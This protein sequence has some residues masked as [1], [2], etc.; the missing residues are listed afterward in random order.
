M[1]DVNGNKTT[2]KKEMVGCPMTDH[3]LHPKNLIFVDKTGC[4]TNMKQDGLV[5]GELHILPTEINQNIEFG[6]CGAT[7]D[8]HFSVLCFTNALGKPIQ[9]AIILKSSKEN[10]DI[11]LSWRVGVDI[12]K[13]AKTG[14]TQVNLFWQRLEMKEY[15]KEVQRVNRMVS[16]Y[17]VLL[18]VVPALPS[19]LKCWQQC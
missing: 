16:T 5:G 3:L 13:E 2:N 11:P 14:E 9:S 6:D 15:Y 8:I 12:R 18:E 17:L 19:P 1:C 7:T 4:N 10:N